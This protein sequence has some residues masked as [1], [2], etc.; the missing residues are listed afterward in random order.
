M[1][2]GVHYSTK[3]IG[4]IEGSMGILSRRSILKR[5]DYNETE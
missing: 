5:P 1:S 2:N 4:I 3:Y